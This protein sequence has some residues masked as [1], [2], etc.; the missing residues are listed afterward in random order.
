MAVY[1]DDYLFATDGSGIER[2]AGIS[3]RL[4]EVEGVRDVLSL[5]QVNE[6]LQKLQ[7][8]KKAA[9]NGRP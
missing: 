9:K 7:Q 1:R 5:A 2:L 4:K 3:Q 6:L 8:G